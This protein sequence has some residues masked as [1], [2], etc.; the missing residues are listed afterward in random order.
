MRA[1]EP[2]STETPITD[3]DRMHFYNLVLQDK[4]YR[5][6]ARAKHWIGEAIAARLRLNLDKRADKRRA[7][8]IFDSLVSEGVLAVEEAED[9]TRRVRDFVAPGPLPPEALRKMAA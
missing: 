5:A 8:A 9:L 1:R 2:P 6:H 3:E 4:T 7:K